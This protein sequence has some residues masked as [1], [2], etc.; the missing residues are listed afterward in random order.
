MQGNKDL[1]VTVKDA[2]LLSQAN[3]NAELLIV[4][5]MNH[6]MKT[7]EGDTTGEYGKL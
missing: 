6:V 5:K 4:D 3:T 2:E 7:I 1:Q